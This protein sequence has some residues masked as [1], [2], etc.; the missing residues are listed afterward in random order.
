MNLSRIEIVKSAADR[1]LCQ[2]R[3]A[4]LF[5]PPAGRGTREK[6]SVIKQAGPQK[7]G[8]IR[9]APGKTVHVN[10]YLADGALYL[11]DLPGYGYARASREERERWGRLMEAYFSGGGLIAAGLLV[12]DARRLPGEDDVMM[13]RWFLSSGLPLAVVAN[14]TDK[15]KRSELEGS[16]RAIEEALAPAGPVAVLPF[17]ARTGE[18][19]DALLRFMEACALRGAPGDGGGGA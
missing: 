15:L 18:G 3:K 19:R 10:Y 11:V 13:A 1:R 8:P 9:S 16:L 2:G 4:Q 17:S 12:V 14:K 7:P 5:F 6:S